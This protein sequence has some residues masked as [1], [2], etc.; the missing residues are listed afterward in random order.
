M[1]TLSLHARPAQAGLL[2][3]MIAVW[4]VIAALIGAVLLIQFAP[5]AHDL[6]P[7]LRSLMPADFTLW[8]GFSA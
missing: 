2:I 6:E 7:V 8:S 5:T 4:L 3:V 1:S